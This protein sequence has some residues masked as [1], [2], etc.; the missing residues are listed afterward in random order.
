MAMEILRTK[1]QDFQGAITTKLAI[2][3]GA[4]GKVGNHFGRLRGEPHFTPP[5]NKDQKTSR[6]SV[7]DRPE[8]RPYSEATVFYSG[9]CVPQRTHGF[10]WSCSPSAERDYNVAEFSQNAT[11]F[12]NVEKI[13][14]GNSYFG[15]FPKTSLM[16]KFP[17][18]RYS[19]IFLPFGSPNLAKASWEL[20]NNDYPQSLT[21]G[22]EVKL[23]T[24]IF[25]DHKAVTPFSSAT[26]GP[27]LPTYNT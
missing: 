15:S 9:N 16:S 22:I 25:C 23:Y 1:E 8:D 7:Q 19:T 18:T 4:K 5:N 24:T 13:L 2:K 11:T 10:E 3:F 21:M 12:W 26:E 14:P 27:F 20:K 17:R 6:D